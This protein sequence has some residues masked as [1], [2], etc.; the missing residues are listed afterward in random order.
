MNEYLIDRERVYVYLFAYYRNSGDHGLQ[1]G[2][3]NIGE[4]VYANLKYRRMQMRTSV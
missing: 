4:G 2:V 1:A 3:A